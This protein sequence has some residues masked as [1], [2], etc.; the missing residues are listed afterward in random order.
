MEAYGKSKIATLLFTAELDRRLR[1][2]GFA[3]KAVAAHP[4]YSNT[5]PGKGGFFMRLAT[6]IVAQ[7]AA[8]GALPQLYAATAPDVVGGDYYGPGGLAEMRGY[9]AK[10]DCTPAAK[11]QAMAARLWDLSE[12]LTGVSF[13]E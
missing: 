10:V 7:P 2:A 11:D 3:A 9:P 13:L 8:M 6:S 4:G 5:N 12:K 1:K